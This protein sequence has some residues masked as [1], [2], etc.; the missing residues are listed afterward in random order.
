[1]P[2]YW[3]WIFAGVLLTP[4]YFLLTGPRKRR[5]GSRWKG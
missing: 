4:L 1:V 3:Y 2:S 5:I